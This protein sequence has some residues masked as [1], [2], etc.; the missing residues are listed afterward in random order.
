M[1]FRSR[2]ASALTGTSPSPRT[3]RRWLLGGAVAGSLL[4]LLAFAPAAW[5]AE[6]VATASRDHFLLA[7]T[8]G[9]VWQGSALPVLSGGPGTRDASVLPSRLRWSV[10]PFWGGL[11]ARLSQPC[12]LNG[13]L[14]IDWSPGWQHQ[15]LAVRPEAGGQVGHWPAAWLEGLGAPLNTLRLGGE[16]QLS[17]Q[18]LRLEQREGRWLLRGQAQL[19]LL[20][21]SSR[22]ASLDPLGS[23]RLLLQQPQAGAPA[24]LSLST[25][26]GALR[27]MG[28]GHITP[29]G[30]QFRA[31]A[32]AA[33][34]SEAAL[35]NLLNIMGRRDGAL[36]RISI[37]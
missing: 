29:R 34:G 16:L 6:A 25:L 18:D 12:C 20:Q 28:S 24:Q 19:D 31:E 1:P 26:D 2:P 10:R 37:G 32:Q 23:Y 21:T 36:S 27:L 17:T 14:A 4:A 8:E 33:P 3:G 30:L 13:T 15:A 11:R 5:L 22:L 9:T 7:E 35:N